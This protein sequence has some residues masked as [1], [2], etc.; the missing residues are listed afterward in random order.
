M[1]GSLNMRR[2]LISDGC[3]LGIKINNGSFVL[4]RIQEAPQE[5]IGEGGGMRWS[6]VSTRISKSTTGSN[7]HHKSP[8]LSGYEDTA[9]EPEL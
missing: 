9:K 8:S 1:C 2:L 3:G 6:R 5:R 4:S 7:C